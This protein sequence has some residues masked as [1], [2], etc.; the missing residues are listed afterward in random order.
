MIYFEDLLLVIN[1]K[2]TMSKVE[3]DIR[4]MFFLESISFATVRTYDNSL[5][6]VMGSIKLTLGSSLIYPQTKFQVINIP[7]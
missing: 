7:T 6:D 2:S 3:K 1:E 4:F 5:Q